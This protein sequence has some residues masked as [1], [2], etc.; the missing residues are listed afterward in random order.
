MTEIFRG[1]TEQD[2]PD[3]NKSVFNYL[4][5]GKFE[6]LTGTGVARLTE[7]PFLDMNLVN[8]ICDDLLRE[9]AVPVKERIPSLMTVLATDL[10]KQASPEQLV[11]ILEWGVD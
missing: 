1:F 7:L 5:H 3:F 2:D 4:E 6:V 10:Y 11:K 8:R 9:N